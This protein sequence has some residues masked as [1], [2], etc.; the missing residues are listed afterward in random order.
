MF[1]DVEGTLGAP[2]NSFCM[3]DDPLVNMRQRA[4]QCR[5]LAKTIND[6]RAI[7]ILLQMALE[8][9]ADIAR[10]SGATKPSG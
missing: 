10:L 2:V 4:E 5:R 7:E 9:E 3:G 6:Q 1:R 8:V